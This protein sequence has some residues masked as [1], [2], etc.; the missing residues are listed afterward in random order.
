MHK[1]PRKVV[2]PPRYKA[3]GNVKLI[4]NHPVARIIFD[5][6]FDWD[7][8]YNFIV[9]WFKH[10]RYYFEEKDYKYKIPSPA[11]PEEEFK[12]NGWRN[13]TD[14]YRYS[15]DLHMKT[16]GIKKI[17]IVEKG[18]KKTIY[19][20]KFILEFRGTVITDYQDRLK[21]SV[22]LHNL[23]NFLDRFIFSKPMGI[24]WGDRLYYI[25]LKFHARIKEHLNM[26][27]K[28]HAYEDVW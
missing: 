15:I 4:G 12:W 27:G 9:D 11:G 16:Y 26:E 7:G 21:G 23:K 24:V 5:G 17:E 1:E 14:Y 2:R 13:I 10:R 6:I 25:I 3:G 28:G 19:K 8:L 20:G 18:K 22:F